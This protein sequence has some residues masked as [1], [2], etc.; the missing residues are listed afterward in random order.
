MV[1]AILDVDPVECLGRDL[2]A[3]AI[4]SAFGALERRLTDCVS[5][6]EAFVVLTRAV[7]A[8]LAQR[9]DAGAPRRVQEAN[10]ALARGG[11]VHAVARAVGMSERSLH[12][13][14]VRWSGLAPKSLARIL[15]MQRCLAALRAGRM[16]LALLALRLG[17]ADQA[18]MTREL[19][20][21][22]GVTPR[23]VARAVSVRNLQDA[24]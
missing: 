2:P 3:Q 16:P 10:A 21:L 4:D 1:R 12:R 17:Y 22:A 8:R 19:K 11:E 18:H 20:A 13:D 24:A 15:R 7:D 14:V 23:E 6:D 9:E 5:A